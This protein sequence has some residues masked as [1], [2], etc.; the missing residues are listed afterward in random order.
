VFLVPG[1]T[2][3]RVAVKQPDLAPALPQLFQQLDD[4]YR[5]LGMI[6]GAGWQTAIVN[7]LAIAEGCSK[8]FEFMMLSS[9]KNGNVMNPRPGMRHSRSG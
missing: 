1:L 2:G 9:I 7:D 6:T 4:R 3:F 8:I 5:C